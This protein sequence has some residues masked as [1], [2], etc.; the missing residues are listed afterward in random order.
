DCSIVGDCGAAYFPQL[1]VNAPSVIQL[2][3][4]AGGDQTSLAG[5]IPV[6][7]SAGGILNWTATVT[8]QNGSGW[9]HLDN[10]SGQNFGSI[11][12]TAN[13]KNLTAR[14]Y[15]AT[16][17]ID[18]GSAGTAT[19][20]VTLTVNPGPP[21]TAVV[22]SKIIN[23]ATLDATPLVAGSLGTLIGTHFAGKSVGVS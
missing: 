7:N 2:T 12:V 16:I 13:A 19:V 22:V 9:L 10:T 1:N 21:P 3:A 17:L 5:Y 4:N 20:P 11:I 15:K 14:V 6:T 18:A 8:Y 23:A